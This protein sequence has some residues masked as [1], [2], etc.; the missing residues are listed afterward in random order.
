VSGNFPVLQ[1]YGTGNNTDGNNG[2]YNSGFVI[3]VNATTLDE[4]DIKNSNL[5]CNAG[6]TV[7]VNTTTTC[8]FNLPSGKSIPSNLKFGIGNST[9]SGTCTAI[10]TLVTCINVPAGT[11]V[12]NNK[13]IF[14]QFGTA[15]KFDTTKAIN[16]TGTD[17]TTTDLPALNFVCTKPD[18]STPMITISKAKCSFSLPSGKTLPANF[19]LALGDSSLGGTC[20]IT[21]INLAVVE[22][23][24]V[25]TGTQTPTQNLFA[26]INNSARTDTTKF[27]S[28]S[29]SLLTSV[30]GLNISCSNIDSSPVLINTTT[31]CT[32]N[33]PEGSAFTPGITFGIGNVSPAGNCVLS[34]PA[35]AQ[36]T[37]NNVPV[38]PDSGSIPIFGKIP[39]KDKENTGKFAIV[40]GVAINNGDLINSD[41]QCGGGNNIL[42]NS[43]TTCKFTLP[44]S[45]F[46]P[47]VFGLSVGDI[48]PG[49]DCTVGPSQIVTCTNVPTGPTIGP[50]SIFSK[51]NS[52][53]KENTNKTANLNR[54]PD[55]E[56]PT[57]EIPTQV[58]NNC[59]AGFFPTS[60]KCEICPTDSYCT[61]QYEYKKPC[62]KDYRNQNLG[63]KS[64]TECEVEIEKTKTDCP[65]GTFLTY[66][67]TS[68]WV[69]VAG[70]YCEGGMSKPIICTFGKY[71][72]TGSS[73]SIECK[74]GYKTN[75]E[76]STT[77]S[78]CERGMMIEQNYKAIRTGSL[79]IS[80]Q[81]LFSISAI[82]LFGLIL[83]TDKKDKSNQVWKKI[84]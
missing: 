83:T 47:N 72:P 34:N 22:C 55:P 3:T 41:L 59:L 60:N 27:F 70:Y 30:I 21:N 54:L 23:V 33:L 40:G 9:P 15:S 45:K 42:I 65:I 20:S 61:G 19:K 26:S 24:N 53:N 28:V 10:A 14:G 77:E 50:N 43:S 2:T 57:E 52:G 11:E 37:C 48:N 17:L 1:I 74:Q 38:G 13:P 84:K 44:A 63:K 8:T 18:G 71:C 73:K 82:G 16:V 80:N 56:K 4:N 69:C 32:Y 46:L 7:P 75:R 31:T 58:K 68:C 51:I 29:G 49:G 62:P 76:G 78:E 64:I 25:N 5:I 66:D 35:N 39:N 36:V 12:G 79:N 81:T 6:Q 67:K